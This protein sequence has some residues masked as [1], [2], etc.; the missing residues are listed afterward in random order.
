MGAEDVGAAEA[1]FGGEGGRCPDVGDVICFNGACGS[2]MWVQD[3][4]YVPVHWENNR[5]LPPQGGPKA[6][7]VATDEGT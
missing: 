2:S 5:Q 3:V 6:D 1:G 4:G 7:G